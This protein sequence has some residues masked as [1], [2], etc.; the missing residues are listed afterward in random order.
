MV[1]DIARTPEIISKRTA[2]TFSIDCSSR[3]IKCGF[4]H[5]EIKL[6]VCRSVVILSRN[7][8]EKTQATLDGR[9]P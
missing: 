6:T 5:D 1:F 2:Y 7:C 4:V 3:E 9:Q 8:C